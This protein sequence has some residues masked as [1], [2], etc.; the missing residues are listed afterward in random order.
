[1]PESEQQQA[2]GST[3]QQQQLQAPPHPQAGTSSSAHV[4]LSNLPVEAYE[5]T[6]RR[7]F[8]QQGIQVVSPTQQHVPG[9]QL[10]C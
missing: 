3:S 10:C 9:Q 7:A 6:I 5:G 2:T 8:E 4:Y 1:M